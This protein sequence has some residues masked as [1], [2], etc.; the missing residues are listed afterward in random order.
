MNNLLLKK[1]VIIYFILYYINVLLNHFISVNFKEKTTPSIVFYQ[2]KLD[3]IL[4]VGE[5][6]TKLCEICIPNI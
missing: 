6:C 1:L 4:E 5:I 3:I 2:E